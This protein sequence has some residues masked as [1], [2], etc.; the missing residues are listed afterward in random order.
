[1]GVTK[2]TTVIWICD[3]CEKEIISDKKPN[4][5]SDPWGYFKVDQDAGFDFQ[6]YPW[7]PRMREPILLCGS[8]I[9]DIVAVINE[10]PKE[11]GR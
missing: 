3:R 2:T 8:C 4:S 9:E 6:G 1:M 10:K 11:K 7:A 5:P